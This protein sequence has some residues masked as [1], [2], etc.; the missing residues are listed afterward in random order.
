MKRVT[1]T[2]LITRYVLKES[3]HDVASAGFMKARDGTF[4]RETR[5][6]RLETGLSRE[7]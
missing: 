1:I 3:D 5:N 6:V 2:Q 4:S 7:Y